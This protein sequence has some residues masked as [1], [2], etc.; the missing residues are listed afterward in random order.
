MWFFNAWN[1]GCC[2]QSDETGTEVFDYE[3]PMAYPADCE[4]P[5]LPDPMAP[6]RSIVARPVLRKL[7]AFYHLSDV[8]TGVKTRQ[9]DRT[10]AF[11]DKYYRAWNAV[12]TDGW[13]QFMSLWAPDSK[14]IWMEPFA[15]AAPLRT[16]ADIAN[17]LESFPSM[18]VRKLAHTIAQDEQQGAC[19]SVFHLQDP[20]PG[21]P[22]TI[23]SVEIFKLN[24]AGQLV[25]LRVFWHP[26]EIGGASKSHQYEITARHVRSFTEALNSSSNGLNGNTWEDQP[27]EVEVEFHDPVG[28]LA[29]KT[30]MLVEAYSAGLPPFTATL[31]MVRVGQD[32]LKAAAVVNIA[33]PH[34]QLLP[35]FPIIFTFDFA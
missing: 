34:S 11:V 30:R 8:G 33:F 15:G 3:R 17:F 16:R 5:L 28:T 14:G 29:R 19:A 27:K 1:Q 12:E 6:P 24:A 26:S 18:S 13:G 4:P 31:R 20:P 21:V 35:P 7:M 25:F 22:S 23:N 32:E 9:F 10:A 2:C